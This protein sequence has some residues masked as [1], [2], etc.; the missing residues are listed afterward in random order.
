MGN[1][2]SSFA[3]KFCACASIAFL[4]GITLALKYDRLISER[5]ITLS[6]FYSTDCL[7]ALFCYQNEQ[8]LF[9][10]LKMRKLRIRMQFMALRK[11]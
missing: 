2:D 11:V 7:S 5:A 6:Q 9:F 3:I 1:G 8:E 4:A 10:Y